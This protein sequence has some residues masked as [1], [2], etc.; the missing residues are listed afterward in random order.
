MTL[1]KATEFF[2]L[3]SKDLVISNRN[4]NLKQRV[5]Q[6]E[7]IEIIH[8]SLYQYKYI[9]LADISSDINIFVSLPDIRPI[10]KYFCWN[11]DDTN[12]AYTVYI[13]EADT[14]I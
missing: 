14:N 1:L 9:L 6:F 8:N 13:Q 5:H 7:L 12:I 4:I 11:L 2:L 10:S 3:L